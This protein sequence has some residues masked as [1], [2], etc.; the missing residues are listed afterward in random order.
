LTVEVAIP[1]DKE[2]KNMEMS[3]ADLSDNGLLQRFAADGFGQL[4]ANQMTALCDYLENR[5]VETGLAA[6][7]FVSEAI[8]AV[9]RLFREHDGYGGVRRDFVDHLDGLVRDYL[10]T[11]QRGDPLQAARRARQFRDEVF[12]KASGYNSRAGMRSELAL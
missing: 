3:V 1:L 2:R 8:Q 12:A 6:P 4:N 10:P 7:M 9:E 11:I 5:A